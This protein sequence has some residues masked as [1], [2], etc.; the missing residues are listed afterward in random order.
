[1]ATRAEEP[2]RAPT[3]IIS[4]STVKVS[5]EVDVTVWVYSL[6]NVNK[7]RTL[8]RFQIQRE[9]LTSH[10]DYSTNCFIFIAQNGDDPYNLHLKDDDVGAMR[11]WF[12]YLQAVFE[13][14]QAEQ[15]RD[16]PSKRVKMDSHSYT[17]SLDEEAMFGRDGVHDTD[18]CRIWHIINAA[19]KYMLDASILEAFFGIWYRKNVRIMELVWNTLQTDTSPYV[20]YMC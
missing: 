3:P 10:S 17:T 4:S 14:E 1:M 7:E 5:R 16:R 12:E 20:Q 6:K 19:D 13:K 15:Y 8:T 9:A 11:V 2:P 18:I